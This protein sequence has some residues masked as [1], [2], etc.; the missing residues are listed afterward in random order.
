MDFSKIKT[1]YMIGIKGVGMT[2]LAE[3]LAHQKYSISGS[4][5]GEVFMTDSVLEKAGI[6]VFS[7]FSSENLSP[8]PDLVIYSTAYNEN[9]NE[10]VKEA[11]LRNLKLL[12]FA[13]ALGEIFNTHF[14]IAVCGSHGKTTTTAWLGFVLEKAGLQPNVM[15]GARV[16]QFNGA[17][18]TGNSNLLVVETDEY[19]NKLQ[20]FN[21]KMI[22]LNNIDYD[23]PDFFPTKESYE[24][25]FVNFIQKLPKSGCLIANIDDEII[26]TLISEHS[27][28]KVITYGVHNEAD[29]R[30]TDIQYQNG[31]QYF[32]VV[33]KKSEDIEENETNELG[34]FSISLHGH[35]NI[36]NALSI[37]AASLELGADL[38]LVRRYLSEFTG[39]SRRLEVLGEYKG[40]TIIDDYAHHPTEIQA[41]LQ[42]VK[43]KYSDKK[44]R[45][46]FHPHTFTRTKALITDFGKSFFGAD[47]VVVLG[48]YGS[49]REEQGGVTSEEVVIEIKKNG[50]ENVRSIHTLS[51]VE[52]YLR[53]SVQTDE[54]IVL[55]GAGDVFR[56]GENLIKV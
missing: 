37:I 56:V 13:E 54:V 33:L 51:E 49:A 38:L 25:V 15:V 24:T 2:M 21:P 30:A 14:G 44:I 50:L 36:L 17:G 40:A 19:Q 31:K 4:D 16:P 45:V 22:L 46:I 18:L 28:S 53:S 9:T 27:H 55:M 52:I 41:T 42:A 6:S 7:G 5:T 29:Y 48:I 35:H 23:H 34:N 1:I 26:R 11:K 3:F 47:E 32:N 20:Y 8:K 43:Q 10:E 12:T 39:T